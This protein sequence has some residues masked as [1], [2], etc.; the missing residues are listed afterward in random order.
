MS[1]VSCLRLKYLT[2]TLS[3]ENHLKS[4]LNW[5]VTSCK[6]F[7]VRLIWYQCTGRTGNRQNQNNVA[8][9]RMQRAEK[10]KS[11]VDRGRNIRKRKIYKGIHIELL[12]MFIILLSL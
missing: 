11:E 6:L 10:K 2:F 8:H 1:I 5:K 3:N 4:V 7:L 12:T 9:P